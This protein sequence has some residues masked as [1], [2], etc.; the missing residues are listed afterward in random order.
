MARETLQGKIEEVSFKDVSAELTSTAAA[1]S[2][3]LELTSVGDFSADEGGVV[4]VGTPEEVTTI[5][6]GEEVVEVVDPLFLNY[7]TVDEEENT[8]TLYEPLEAEILV[9]TELF[10]YPYAQEKI[11]SV[12]GDEGDDAVEVRITYP[13]RDLPTGVRRPL[14]QETIIYSLDADGEYESVDIPSQPGREGG[15]SLADLDDD[16]GLIMDELQ[17]DLEELNTIVLPQLQLDLTT[18]N[19]ELSNLNTVTLPALQSQLSTAQ[20]QISSI[21]TYDLPYL[22]DTLILAQNDLNN[23]NNVI[24]PG[25]N[26]MF[27]VSETNIQDGAISTPKMVANSINGDRITANTLNASKIVAGSI[28]TDRM[29]ANSISGDRITANTLNA[30]KIVAGTIYTDLMS[31]NAINGDRIS[32]NTLNASKIVA[33]SITT[34]R[35]TANTISGDRIAANT[36]HADKIVSNSISTAHL[37]A[38]AIDGMTITGSL[39]RTGSSGTRVEISNGTDGDIRFY[40]SFNTLSGFID[41]YQS[42]SLFG[43]NIGAGTS[44]IEMFN[45]GMNIK[46]TNSYG[47]SIVGGVD[48]QGGLRMNGTGINMQ[49]TALSMAGGE[50]LM[51]GA[52]KITGS[53]ILIDS[54]KDGG[55]NNSNTGGKYVRCTPNG[56][57][58]A[59]T[60]APSSRNIKHDIQVLEMPDEVILSI[61]PVSY[62]YDWSPEEVR[63]GAIAQQVAEIG[64]E[65][66][67]SRDEEG[68]PDGFD[69]DGFGL[70]L[71]K[72]VKNQDA[73]IKALEALVG[74]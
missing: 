50:I 37:A 10:A 46:G 52:S 70:A 62:R 53:N 40:N 19:N 68:E 17:Q 11:A 24:I 69:Y 4:A 33:G 47:V 42:G 71:L 8:M 48:L 12:R 6:E 15:I 23:L 14:E 26:G 38:T 16:F 31:A 21:Y 13:F 39:F 32:A 56:T 66:L 34:D 30:G 51:S 20:N 1:G 74:A 72:V 44:R 36:L 29:T 58:Y 25:L 7:A 3:T 2:L 57:L 60:T 9:D 67:I 59:H 22:N 54:L 28:T 43:V 63:V 45:G 65:L 55:S 49:G 64:A 18:A 73:R 61:E 35:M 27:P 41:P 5:V